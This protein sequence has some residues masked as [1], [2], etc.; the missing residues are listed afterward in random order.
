MKPRLEEISRQTRHFAS[1][2]VDLERQVLAVEP[3]E[4]FEKLSFLDDEIRRQEDMHELDALIGRKTG[5]LSQL[6][7]LDESRRRLD[8]QAEEFLTLGAALDT[9]EQELELKFQS[10]L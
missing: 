8:L 5:L 3:R 10:T 2:L 7:E 4:I 9:V 1:H 6:E